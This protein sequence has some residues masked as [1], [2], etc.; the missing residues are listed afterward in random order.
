[1]RDECFHRAQGG[2]WFF[3]PR[4]GSALVWLP[5]LGFRDW[6]FLGFVGQKL[7]AF[8][9]TPEGL[10]TFKGLGDVERRVTFRVFLKVWGLGFLDL[11]MG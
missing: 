4:F 5:W 8:L 7:G 3:F 9:Q 10:G 1:M 2:P 6:G 11:F